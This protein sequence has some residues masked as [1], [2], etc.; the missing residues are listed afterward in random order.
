MMGWFY[1]FKLHLM[2]NHIGEVIYLKITPANT[3]DITPIPELCKKLTGKLSAD[4]SYIGK[5]LSEKL[6]ETDV[7]LVTTVR[8]NMKARAISAFDRAMLSLGYVI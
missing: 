2:I 6:S 3:N 7:D 1:V 5:K 4:K 8:K